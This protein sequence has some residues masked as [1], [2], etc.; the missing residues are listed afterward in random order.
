ME[1]ELLP[2]LD[3]LISLRLDSDALRA[4]LSDSHSSGWAKAGAVNKLWRAITADKAK[5]LI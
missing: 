3:K 5:Y 4:E 2:C 1:D